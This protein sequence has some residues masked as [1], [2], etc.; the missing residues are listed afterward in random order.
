MQV[1]FLFEDQQLVISHASDPCCWN[2]NGTLA[3]SW[4]LVS[5]SVLKRG[6]VRLLAYC[7]RYVKEAGSHWWAENWCAVSTA[8]VHCR[9]RDTLSHNTC[10]L[11]THI[12][13]ISNKEIQVG[14]PALCSALFLV[15]NA[16]TSGVTNSFHCQRLSCRSLLMKSGLKNPSVLSQWQ[17]RPTLHCSVERSK[18]TASFHSSSH[19]HLFLLPNCCP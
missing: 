10:A 17:S 5:M 8:V 18:T 3:H 12:Q 2:G 16:T 7:Y 1:W 11:H 4:P 9:P 13:N 6:V 14:A 15:I 19:P